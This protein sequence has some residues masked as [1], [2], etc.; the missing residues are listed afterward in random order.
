MWVASIINHFMSFFFE[1]ISIS[2]VQMPFCRAHPVFRWI[3]YFHL[4]INKTTFKYNDIYSHIDIG[5]C[6]IS[7]SDDLSIVSNIIF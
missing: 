6:E 1:R 7:I 2:L 4:L 5:I 3:I